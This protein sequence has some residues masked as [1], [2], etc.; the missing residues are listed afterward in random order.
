MYVYNCSAE[1]TH[2]NVLHN[3]IGDRA[4][5]AGEAESEAAK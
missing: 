3:I 1:V 5:E 4:A 2:Y